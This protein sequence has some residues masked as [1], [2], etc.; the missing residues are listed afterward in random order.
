[1]AIMVSS[2]QSQLV[3]ADAL[4]NRDA[5][6][7]SNPSVDGNEGLSRTVAAL[8]RESRDQNG[9]AQTIVQIVNDLGQYRDLKQ[10][11]DARKALDALSEAVKAAGAVDRHDPAAMQQA[12][13]ALTNDMR[14]L[15][16][17]IAAY[18]AAANAA[19]ASAAGDRNPAGE[20]SSLSK[21]QSG[22]SAS[23]RTAEG[24]TL[25]GDCYTAAE[26][27]ASIDVA[28]RNQLHALHTPKGSTY[29]EIHNDHGGSS[30][31]GK[32]TVTINGVT[33]NL[34]QWRPARYNSA[35]QPI[36]EPEQGTYFQTCDANGKVWFAPME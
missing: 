31:W 25:A 17:A 13:T 14:A 20:S 24:Y 2:L 15:T 10:T 1:M 11:A 35:G 32:S 22:Q 16:E 5:G 3:K 34:G 28:G 21:R 29:Y 8:D 9:T 18:D 33:H 19:T 12:T 6:E 4:E 26:C 7:L 27:Q 30:T 23:T 36:E